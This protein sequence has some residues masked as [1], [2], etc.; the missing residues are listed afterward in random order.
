MLAPIKSPQDLARYLKI[1]PL[2]ASSLKHLSDSARADFLASLTFNEKGLT[3]FKFATLEMELNPTRIAEILSL[4]GM[5]RATPLLVNA[6]IITERDRQ[7]MSSTGPLTCDDVSPLRA[8]GAT[9]MDC[10][11]FDGIGVG[12]NGGGGGPPPSGPSRP[13]PPRPPTMGVDYECYG[14]GACR[15]RR[16]FICD[17]SKC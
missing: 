3:S 5:Q 8:G 1:T 11:L 14:P 17:T 12:D 2:N 4:F 13:L 6:K 15:A 16:G 10:G 9:A 7:L